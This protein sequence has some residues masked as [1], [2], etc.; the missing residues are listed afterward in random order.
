MA[1]W[2][3]LNFNQTRRIVVDWI[4]KGLPLIWIAVGVGLLLFLNI[5]LKLNSVLALIIVA[6]VV[7]VLEGE[8]LDKLVTSLQTGLGGTLGSLA[9]VIAFGAVIG[10]LMVDS[11]A[12]QRVASTLLNKFGKRNVQWAI[13]LTGLI[14]GIAMFYEVAFVILAP[15]VISIAIEAEISFLPLAMTMVAAATTAHSLFPP[16]PGPTAL[17]TAYHADMGMVYILGIIVAI[18]TIICSGIILPKL[19]RKHLKHSVPKIYQKT[20]S[21]TEEDMPSL[22]LVF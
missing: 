12:A 9:L 6:L 13:L 5:K 14:F 4:L 11:G 2:N 16:Q 7:A 21:F 22:V 19:M 17:V 18:P 8:P 20:K 1:L 3:H 10:K 15:L